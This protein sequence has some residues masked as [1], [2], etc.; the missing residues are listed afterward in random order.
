MGLA[1]RAGG[2]SVA[3]AIRGAT[4]VAAD[5]L[6]LGDEIGSLEVGKRADIVV[7]AVP[8][9]AHLAYRLGASP[10]THVVKDGAV[11]IGGAA[12]HGQRPTPAVRPVRAASEVAR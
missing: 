12:G 7:V 5:A 1:C 9:H 10:V 8:E 2:L 3:E 6:G 4:L 11:V